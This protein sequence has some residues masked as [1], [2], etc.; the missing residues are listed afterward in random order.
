MKICLQR[1]RESTGNL[2]AEKRPESE[3]SP[4]PAQARL[5]AKARPTRAQSLV[6]AETSDPS[7]LPRFPRK[8]LRKQDFYVAVPSPSEWVLRAK[9][10]EVERKALVD[11]KTAE[12]LQDTQ[13][14]YAVETIGAVVRSQMEHLHGTVHDSNLLVEFIKEKMLEIVPR[15]DGQGDKSAQLT[16]PPLPRTPTWGRPPGSASLKR[17]RGVEDHY[18]DTSSSPARSRIGHE[19][20]PS[21]RGHTTPRLVISPPLANL[22]SPETMA[23][24]FRYAS[25]PLR[26]VG[27]Q[28]SPDD[29]ILLSP[30]VP[31]Y[32]PPTPYSSSLRDND[33]DYNLGRE[34][35]HRRL[36]RSQPQ[37]RSRSAPRG[38]HSRYRSLH[39]PLH[40]SDRR[41][42][43][44]SYSDARS[45]D[46]RGSRR[47]R[48]LPG[49][50]G[51]GGG[52]TNTIQFNIHSDAGYESLFPYTLW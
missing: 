31:G 52:A 22:H 5:L 19:P 26:S 1:A 24:V 30:V 46:V 18:G 17:N 40:P 33:N 9:H 39:T 49:G 8:P 14:S 13:L 38:G 6:S 3:T 23:S 44:Y 4:K 29:D 34:F 32:I 27:S 7:S 42:G 2:R 20:H 16:L 47:A 50:G 43:D 36:S 12:S 28:H 48:S 15:S 11:G 37:S 51:G 25:V 35:D 10:R 21:P 41:N 45:P